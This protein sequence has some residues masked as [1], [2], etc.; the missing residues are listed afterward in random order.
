MEPNRVAVK[1][2]VH[3]L[4]ADVGGGGQGGDVDVAFDHKL[5]EP[6]RVDIVD[7]GRGAH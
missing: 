3:R 7:K 1:D 4:I 6:G 5:A 2:G